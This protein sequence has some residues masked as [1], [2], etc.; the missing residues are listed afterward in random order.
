MEMVF[1]YVS[2]PK[3]S[4]NAAKKYGA[5]YVLII[6]YDLNKFH[7]MWKAA[8]TGSEPQVFAIYNSVS[9]REEGGKVFLEYGGPDRN[10]TVTY[11]VK[12]DGSTAPENITASI[13]TPQGQAYVENVGIGDRI[14]T[15][16]IS[17]AAPGLIYYSGNAVVYV[18]EAVQ[19]SAFVR[20]YLF[21]G[22][23]AEEYFEK[24]FD[25]GQVKIYK[26]L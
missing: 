3:E 26:V 2:P 17:N 23:G 11:S 9:S 4:V 10:I 14:F 25:N 19:D 22:A 6:A 15:S 18:P 5:E 1:C 20:L 12:G 13:K 16:D 8:R 7:A 21:N 24:V